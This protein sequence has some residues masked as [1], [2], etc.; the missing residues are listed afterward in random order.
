MGEIVAALLGMSGAILVAL[1]GVW[2]ARKFGIG[3]QQEKLVSTLKD[4]VAAQTLQI[5]ALEKGRTEDKLVIDGLIKRVDDLE[6]LT[7]F[8]ANEIKRLLLEQKKGT[9]ASI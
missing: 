1:I 7:V 9:H 4:L 8:Q 3:V 5:Q 2:G 6:A